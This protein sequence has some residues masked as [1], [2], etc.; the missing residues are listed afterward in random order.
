MSFEW[1]SYDPRFPV[2]SIWSGQPVVLQHALWVIYHPTSLTREQIELEVDV[3]AWEW[4]F[5][6]KPC[7]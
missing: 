5:R 4:V 7:E 3:A 2:R 1:P 6:E